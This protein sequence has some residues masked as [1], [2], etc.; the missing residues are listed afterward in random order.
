MQTEHEARDVVVVAG[1]VAPRQATTPDEFEAA[2]AQLSQAGFVLRGAVIG[3][4][5]QPVRLHGGDKR[6]PEVG[7]GG[8]RE[9][10]AGHGEIGLQE[11]V[12]ES[13]PDP[14]RIDHDPLQLP[15]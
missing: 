1:T 5:R 15:V 11:L 9:G 4:E 13:A 2:F 8:P 10:E 14:G 7:F 6:A 3:V 12:E